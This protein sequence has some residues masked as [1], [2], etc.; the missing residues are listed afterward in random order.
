MNPRLGDLA[1]VEGCGAY[2]AGM[3]AKNYNSFPE[4]P[5]VSRLSCLWHG[6]MAPGAHASAMYAYRA[7]EEEAKDSF[8]V[9]LCTA[10]RRRLFSQLGPARGRELW[11]VF[12]WR[13]VGGSFCQR[14]WDGGFFSQAFSR[15]PLRCLYLFASAGVGWPRAVAIALF[16]WRGCSTCT[17]KINSTRSHEWVS[18][19]A[20]PPP[21]ESHRSL[22]FCTIKSRNRSCSTPGGSCTS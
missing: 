11:V 4:A 7:R 14:S 5:E 17:L 2:V 22:V 16:T 18:F 1:V 6:R 20:H 3:S 8:C 15:F 19:L 13:G 10:H 12:L 9:V 21:R